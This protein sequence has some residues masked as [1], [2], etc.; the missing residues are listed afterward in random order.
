MFAQDLKQQWQ[1]LH[2]KW[3]AANK[4]AEK[5]EREL[6]STLRLFVEKKAEPPT[7]RLIYSVERAR[8]EAGVC[9]IAAD[10]FVDHLFLEHSP[11]Q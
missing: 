1:L 3:V 6:L 10:L 11:R 7:S 2:A 4:H 8:G 5:L 9:R